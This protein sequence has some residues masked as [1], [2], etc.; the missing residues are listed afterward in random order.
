MYCNALVYHD[1][2]VV[3]VEETLVIGDSLPHDLPNWPKCCEL[4]GYEFK[5][6]DAWQVWTNR[7]YTRTDTGEEMT[8]REA[9]FGAM[10][11]LDK[12]YMDAGPDGIALAVKL[13]D[14]GLHNIRLWTPDEQRSGG[15]WQRTGDPRKPETLSIT[16]SILASNPPRFHAFL[17]NGKLQVLGDSEPWYTKE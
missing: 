11:D 1:E 4:C 2:I 8:T 15:G 13:P 7:F 3:P 5:D 14:A 16:P 6:N 17:T 9:P 12:K 10:W